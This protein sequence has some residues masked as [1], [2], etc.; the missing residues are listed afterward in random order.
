VNALRD[1]QTRWRDST[2]ATLRF[3][4]PGRAEVPESDYDGRLLSEIVESGGVEAGA[5]L[6]AYRLQYWF[7][8]ITLLQ[9]DF[10]LVGHILGWEDFNPLAAGYLREH[11]PTDDLD[12][13]G[14]ALPRWL[15][16]SGAPALAVEASRV[17]LAWN[18]AFSA[19]ELR[20]PGFAD[21]ERLGS[22]E[23]G[24]QLQP[25]IRILSATRDWFPLRI[26]L[27][28]GRS[29]LPGPP[30]RLRSAWVV[31]RTGSILRAEAVEPLLAGFLRDMRRHSW[32]EALERLAGSHP[33]STPSI[34][35]W[36]ARGLALG[37]WGMAG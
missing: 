11:P 1:F 7:R 18:Q 2:S 3:P 33:E 14:D 12:R 6:G 31:S 30:S 36:F 17:D 8:L 4:E 13:V 10:P 37:W 24:I 15:R 32:L 5:R 21:L 35:D 25:A 22:G 34:P 28:E 23:V 16:A 9:K 19:P 26:S 29:V 20:T 27:Q